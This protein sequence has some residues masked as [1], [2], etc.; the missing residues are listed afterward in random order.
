M[1]LSIVIPAHNE[2]LYLP[3][4]LT[5]ITKALD[6]AGWPG[7]IVVVDNDSFDKSSLFAVC[8]L[9]PTDYWLLATGRATW[10]CVQ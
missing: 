8:C 2:E 3:E 7:E 1:Q 10:S 4:T 5:R 9:L 6:V